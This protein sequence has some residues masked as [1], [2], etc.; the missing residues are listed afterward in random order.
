MKDDNRSNEADNDA[1]KLLSFDEVLDYMNDEACASLDLRRFAEEGRERLQEMDRA[2]GKPEQE[3]KVIGITL[4]MV[5]HVPGDEIT[6]V[7]LREI[8]SWQDEF[9]PDVVRLVCDEDEDQA[10]GQIKEY[11]GIAYC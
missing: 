7:R 4:H 1:N 3:M 10:F 5:T 9:N 11:Q 2:N 6:L 8:T